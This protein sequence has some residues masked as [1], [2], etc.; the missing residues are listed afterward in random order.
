MIMKVIVFFDLPVSTKE[1]R[2]QYLQFRKNL[3]KSGFIMV[4]FSVYART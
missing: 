3:I 4:Q 1:K 2:K